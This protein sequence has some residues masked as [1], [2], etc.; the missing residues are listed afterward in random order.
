MS[1]TSKAVFLSYRRALSL[2]LTARVR[3]HL[4]AQKYDVFFDIANIPSGR[5]GQIILREIGARR[6]FVPILVPACFVRAVDPDDWFRREVERAL[7][8]RRQI[9]PLIAKGFSFDE[10]R[11]RTGGDLPGQL[12]EL[13]SF[14]YIEL[15]D[16]YFEAAMNKLV[17]GLTEAPLE[18]AMAPRTTEDERAVG[19]MSEV[20]R[21]ATPNEGRTAWLLSANPTFAASSISSR[22]STAIFGLKPSR[23]LLRTCPWDRGLPSP[24]LEVE[25]ERSAGGRCVRRLAWDAV[26]GARRYALQRDT[27]AAFAEPAEIYCLDLPCFADVD[28][29]PW[30][31]LAD[32]RP[33]YYR[34]KAVGG[35]RTRD[36]DW[37]N[38]VSA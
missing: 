21:A 14:H 13:S 3:D 20:A 34:V 19:Q 10:E 38:V 23:Q 25:V 1:Y 26:E 15:H 29:D 2:D 16:G 33:P 6:L 11:R 5:F 4:V 28:T 9:V 8:S 22:T 30:A 31:V 24:T 32:P 35:R 7:A 36:S 18:V 17:A 37:S 27:S 12:E